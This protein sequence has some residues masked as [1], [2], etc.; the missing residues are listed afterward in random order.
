M[1]NYKTHQGDGGWLAYM[2]YGFY[3]GTGLRVDLPNW[4][5]TEGYA[6]AGYT[7]QDLPASFQLRNVTTGQEVATGPGRLRQDQG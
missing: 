2:T 5:T 1:A 6:Q 4:L 3:E 7:W